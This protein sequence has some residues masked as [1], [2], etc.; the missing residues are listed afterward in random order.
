MARKPAFQ[1][2]RVLPHGPLVPLAE[3][4]RWV[5]GSLPGMSL[6]RNM[7]VARLS[8]G[9]LVIHNA[10]ALEEPTMRELEAWGTPAFLVVPNGV[11]RLDA[12]IFLDRYP[13]LS[14]IA[15]RGSR[16]K[17]EEVVKVDATYDQVDLGDESV[18]F[19]P[20]GGV[21]D[22]EGVMIVRSDDGLTVVLNDA[23]FNM[24]RK[25][26]PLGFFFTTLLGSAP[27]PRVSRLAKLVFVKDRKA[28]RRDLERLADLDGLT[29][30]VVAHE[31]VAHGP[32]AVTALRRAAT[33]L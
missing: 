25:R 12:K 21:A 4:L 11:H 16:R 1:T 19:E 20:L 28:L 23:V 9:R 27:G 8:D 26:D 5:W 6:R 17:V 24:D 33:Y 29:R 14:V 32:D 2:W 31:K 15:P 3:N 7:T 30:L 22:A 18:R 10:V 13:S